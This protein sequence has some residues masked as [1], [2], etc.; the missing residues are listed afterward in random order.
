MRSP[1]GAMMNT[2]RNSASPISIWLDGASCVPSACLKKW[3]TM[4]IRVNDVIV[5]RIAGMKLSSVRS[6][7]TCRGAEQRAPTPSMSIRVFPAACAATGVAIA[8]QRATVP[9]RVCSTRRITSIPRG[10]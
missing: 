6:R 2:V 1:T 5:I 7:T 3:K 9:A 8:N 4:T 10:T